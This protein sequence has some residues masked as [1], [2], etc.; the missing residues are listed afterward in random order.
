MFCQAFQHR[1]T[2]GGWATA[3]AAEKKIG[4]NFFWPRNLSYLLLSGFSVIKCHSITVER[5]ERLAK[6]G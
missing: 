2:L 6:N 5:S 3:K 1:R 4:Q